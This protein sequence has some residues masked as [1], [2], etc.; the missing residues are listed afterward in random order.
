MQFLVF[1]ILGD[2]CMKIAICD[3]DNNF[4]NEFNHILKTFCLSNNIEF[5]TD[6]FTSGREILECYLEYDIIFLDIDMPKINGFTVADKINEK[7]DEVK[8]PYIVFITSHDNLVWD[9]QKKR[10]LYFIRKRKVDSELSDVFTLLMKE[11][12]RKTQTSNR[13]SVK[14]S[15]RYVH[16]NIDNICYIDREGNYTVFHMLDGGEY[17][18]R[19]KVE[20]HRKKLSDYGFGQIAKCC[21]VKIDKIIVFSK[22][23][24]TLECG[25]TLPISGPFK[26]QISE[27]YF[28]Y[29]S[30]TL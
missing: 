12:N 26:K 23:E 18:E 13:Y 19:S 3:D 14:D 8:T 28:K 30:D 16:I 20:I 17:R 10:P 15:G 4:I 21:L 7:S 9:A 6:N 25:I 22:D 11:M 27:D 2:I 29:I 1:F 5:T 24:L